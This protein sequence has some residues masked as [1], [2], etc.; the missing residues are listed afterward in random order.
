MTTTGS[1]DTKGEKY[2]TI[3]IL[4]ALSDDKSL[5]LFKIIASAPNAV[6]SID[7][8]ELINTQL[9]I[10]RVKLTRKQ[11]YSRISTLISSGLVKR[12]NGKYLLTSLGKVVYSVNVLIDQAILDHWKLK[13]IDALETKSS[14]GILDEEREKIVNML[15]DN[16]EL[17]GL[18]TTGRYLHNEAENQIYSADTKPTSVSRYHATMRINQIS[19]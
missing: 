15:I 9:L 18:L 8:G 1:T 14:S 3:S 5:D 2:S 6:Y 11:Y 19:K 16:H 4:K 7:S 13:A 17:K 12:S 10:S